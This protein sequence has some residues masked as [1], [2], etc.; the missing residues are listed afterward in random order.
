V[1]RREQAGDEASIERVI[2]GAFANHPHSSQNEHLIVKKMR[3]AG[4]MSISLVSLDANGEID[5]HIAFSEV[6]V[7]GRRCNWYGLAPLAVRP[8]RQGK[9]IG[10]ALI[11]QGLAELECE[12]ACGCVVL[13]EPEFY[14]R[15]GFAAN[16]ELVLASVPP[17]YFLSLAIGGE[18]PRGVVRYHDAFA[19]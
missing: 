11:R 8:D 13:G 1:I 12:G 6:T 16:D 2:A 17:E 18:S 14:Q 15:F 5:G 9:G 4:A 3:M 19:I 7:D 10:S